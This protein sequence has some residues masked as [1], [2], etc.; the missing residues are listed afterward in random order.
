[1]SKPLEGKV[2]LVTGSTQGLGAAIARALA[3]AGARLVITGR[4]QERGQAVA[5]TLPGEALFVPAELE[6][7]DDCRRLVAT[8]VECFGRLDILVNSAGNTERSRLET[9]TEALFD[10][11][12][13]TNVQAPL[14]LAQAAVPHLRQHT[15]V[16]INIGSVNAY[17]GGETLLVYS[18]SKAALVTASRN[19]AQA[20]RNERVRV[21]CLNIGWVD[22]DGERAV[23]AG[24]GRPADFIDRAGQKMPLGRLLQPSEIAEV[25][26]FLASDRA[27]AFSGAV[28]DLEQHTI[29]AHQS[30]AFED[31]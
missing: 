7:G 16:V 31:V 20:L 26:L 18:A 2:A 11:Q 25:C 19:L 9:F 8:A 12:F 4:N 24:E 22:T 10:R 15:G 3:E 17:V 6:R 30:V 28:I 23:N 13:K 14:L 21:H 5:R 27:A 29:G 1:M